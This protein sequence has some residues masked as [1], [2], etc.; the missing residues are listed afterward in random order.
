LERSILA[1]YW[2][3][4]AEFLIRRGHTWYSVRRVI[5]IAKPFADH[6][7]TAIAG[8]P[9][10]LNEALVDD[11]LKICEL[12]EARMCLQRLMLFLYEQGIV[13]SAK[14]EVPAT[15]VSPIVEEYRQFLKN[16]R[17]IGT[18]TA[19][20]H[21]L[22]VKSLLNALGNG[23]LQNLTGSVIQQYITDC[24]QRLTRPQRK[25]LCASVRSFLRFLYLRGY[26]SME[27]AST[28]PVIP[29]FK[30]DRLPR[31][32]SRD[33]IEKILAAIDRSSPLG[34]RDYAMLLL[35]ATYGIRAG[36]LCALCLDDID[37]RRQVPRVPGA[38]AG[39]DVFLPL[40]PRVGEAI[41]DYL[42]NGRPV[43]WPFR[44]LFLR[45][46]PPIGPLGGNLVNII[47]PY[48]RKAGVQLPS[49]GSHAWRHACAT[50]MLS[51]GQSLKSIRHIL[52][53]S[54][55]ETTFIYTK[56]DIDALRQAALEW[57]EVA[58]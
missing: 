31:T 26:I 57:P 48:A 25:V 51:K 55:I 21:E 37:W 30:L 11:Y 7:K 15:P 27:L 53:Q 42:R 16:H 40:L 10:R 39:R 1:P 56:V 45:V 58:S 50:R 9:T 36:Q 33:T 44:Q 20:R 24:A 8:D 34:Q 32:V 54:S 23:G 22:Y 12:R 41:V 4:L 28:V 49:F 38:K 2:D 35:V 52:G 29:S 47:K 13:K 17:G 18:A 3:G 5:E 6:V 14:P 46:R 43:G 19:A